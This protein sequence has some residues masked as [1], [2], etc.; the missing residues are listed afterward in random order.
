[1]N[2]HHRVIIVDGEYNLSE[3][4]GEIYLWSGYKS[5]NNSKSLLK[6]LDDSSEKIRESYLKSHR[7]IIQQIYLQIEKNT[8]NLEII[9]NLF[10]SSLTIENSHFKSPRL[11]DVLRLIVLENEI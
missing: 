11:L 3:I 9:R 1:M 2:Y 4:K 5:Q 10:W 6:M 8:N 7:K